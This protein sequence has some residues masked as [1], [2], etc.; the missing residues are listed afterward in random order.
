MLSSQQT[1]WTQFPHASHLPQFTP[2]ESRRGWS[3]WRYLY[4]NWVASL[5]LSSH[6]S[7]VNPNIEELCE[8]SESEST[9]VEASLSRIIGKFGG[10]LLLNDD[11]MIE[12]FIC[13]IVWNKKMFTQSSFK[14]FLDIS[15]M[16]GFGTY[17]GAL[18]PNTGPPSRSHSDWPHCWAK[19]GPALGTQ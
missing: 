6:I 16:C 10:E 12:P 11:G 17:S 5:A 8:S 19:Q 1:K 2:S 18:L 7:H 9:I 15:R 3:S 13:K 14:V 4:S